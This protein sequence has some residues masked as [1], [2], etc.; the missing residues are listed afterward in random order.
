VWVVRERG[1]DRRASGTRSRPV[2][3]AGE[4]ARAVN[5]A[6]DVIK[7]RLWATDWRADLSNALRYLNCSGG[8][9]LA[10]IR[11]EAERLVRQHWAAIEQVAEA[12]IE[13]G[14]LSGDAIDELI[15]RATLNPEYGAQEQMVGSK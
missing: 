11:D 13:R 6:D 14:E 12:L 3:S 2:A 5:N 1:R 9:M 7:P 15:A 10:S 4:R 8:G